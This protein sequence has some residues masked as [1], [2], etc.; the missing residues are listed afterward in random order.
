MWLRLAPGPLNSTLFTALES[1]QRG[2]GQSTNKFRS[3][4]P[5]HL[6]Q[7]SIFHHREAVISRQPPSRWR[8]P[9]ASVL[10][11]IPMPHSDPGLE[12]LGSLERGEQG[13]GGPCR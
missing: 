9:G 13:T 6:I 5:A 3:V 4:K 2:R 12:S 1:F 11:I 10:F 8:L 7:R